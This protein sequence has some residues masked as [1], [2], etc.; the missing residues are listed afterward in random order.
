M[1]LERL[2]D[3]FQLHNASGSEFPD[4]LARHLH[5]DCE[6]V[7]FAASPSAATYRGAAAVA[8]LFRN[9]FEAGSMHISDLTLT[10]VD[11]SRALAAFEVRI[12]G[13]ASGAESSMRMWNL[14][15][16][17][18]DAI[19]RIEEFTEEPGAVSASRGSR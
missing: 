14:F 13:V 8:E 1:D 2:R 16:F 12:R 9:R 18:R 11:D 3:L 19:V 15:T 17:D 10:A 5:P 4:I 6:Y 7:E